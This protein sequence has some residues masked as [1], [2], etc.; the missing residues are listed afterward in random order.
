MAAAQYNNPL[1]YST[2]AYYGAGYSLPGMYESFPKHRAGQ[3]TTKTS[4]SSLL[5]DDPEFLPSCGPS[6]SRVGYSGDGYS[7]PFDKV[8]APPSKPFDKVIAPPARFKALDKVIA[9]PKR[10]PKDITNLPK[11]EDPKEPESPFTKACRMAVAAAYSTDAKFV[12]G[13]FI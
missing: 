7:K 12:A 8:I 5:D 6:L 13:S 3:V 10:V 4:Q 9:P 1:K 2:H 11:K